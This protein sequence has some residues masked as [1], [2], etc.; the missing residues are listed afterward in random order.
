MSTDPD[1]ARSL[2]ADVVVPVADSEDARR[3]AR[4]LHPYQT[5][6]VTV[7]Y[8]VE[9]GGGAPDKTPVEQSE[10]IAAEAFEAFRDVLPDAAE[11]LVYDESIVDGV[12]EAAS[13]VGATAIA[14]QPRG[15]SRVVQF[16]AGDRTLK[17]VTEATVPVV[18]LPEGGEDE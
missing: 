1:A 5:G 3:T 16:L 14:F 8:V 9:K 12:L 4:A 11:E 13:R 2:L 10:R 6:T 15:G 18:S 7:L 17:L